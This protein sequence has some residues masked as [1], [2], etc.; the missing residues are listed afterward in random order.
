LHILALTKERKNTL[1][2]IVVYK[3]YG[4]LC[5]LDELGYKCVHIKHLHIIEDTLRR[6]EIVVLKLGIYVA[7]SMIE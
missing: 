5:T 2:Y 6:D 7:C 1:L 4:N 3:F